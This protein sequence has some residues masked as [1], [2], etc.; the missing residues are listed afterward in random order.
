MSRDLRAAASFLA[1]CCGALLTTATSAAAVPQVWNLALS[2]QAFVEDGEA[3]VSFRVARP[4]TVRFSITRIEPTPARLAVFVVRARTGVNRFVLPGRL[5]RRV[6]TPGTYRLAPAGSSAG[7]VFRVVEKPLV[8]A[9]R[10]SAE[11]NRSRA[12]VVACLVLAIAL[13]GAAA[14][15]GRALGGTRIAEVLVERRSA[16]A[17]TGGLALGAAIGV[18]A[19]SALV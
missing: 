17:V 19:A 3:I 10:P 2:P 18:Y 6:F 12:V 16:L 8:T 15:P 13:L 7:A 5:D 11:R 14:L 1:A 4:A 9:A